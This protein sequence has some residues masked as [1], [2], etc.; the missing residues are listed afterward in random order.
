M[1][2]SGLAVREARGKSLLAML[3]RVQSS[4]LGAATSGEMLQRVCDSAFSSADVPGVFVALYDEAT[5]SLEAAAYPVRLS[6][7][8]EPIRAFLNSEGAKQ[9]SPILKA[10]R[11]GTPQFVADMGK[12]RLPLVLRGMAALLGVHGLAALPLARGGRPIGV[13]ALYVKSRE[14]LDDAAREALCAVALNVSSALERFDE[15]Q[16]LAD[17]EV[18]FRLIVEQ[19]IVG[20]YMVDESRFVY[21]NARLCELMGLTPQ[22]LLQKTLADVVHPEDRALVLRK[23]RARVSGAAE[24]ARY[25]FRIVKPDGTVRDVGVHGRRIE[26]EGRPVEMGVLQDITERVQA[27]KTAGAHVEELR[28]AMHG[29]V[30]AVS[31]MMQMRDSY[32]AGHEERVASIACAIGVEMGLDAFQIEGL[33]VIGGLHDIGKI[34]VPAEILA[35]PSQLTPIEYA[36]VKEH[37]HTGHQIL[38]GIKFPWPVADAVLQH[39][40]RIDGSGYPQGLKNGAILLEARILGIADV[41]ES[42]A[43]HRPYRAALGVEAALA[44]IERGLGTLYDAAAGVAC[45]RLFRQRGYR[46][47][48]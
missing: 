34:A 17:S 29:A 36:L 4:I 20:I 33:D 41:V 22:A 44:E 5:Q 40:E 27:E 7:Y 39:H 1:R 37:A 10:L 28:E 16:R 35:K 11:T 24:D 13:L 9:H 25:E 42:M 45:L 21:G 32:T 18:R 15:R 47:P 38:A 12:L 8:R 30:A 6:P 3:L 46:I 2:T 26:F 31:R 14:L 43:S 19:S 48:D 23:I